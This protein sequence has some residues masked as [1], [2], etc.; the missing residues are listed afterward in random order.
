MTFQPDRPATLKL[1]LSTATRASDGGALTVF[2]AGSITVLTTDPTP[3]ATLTPNFA[4]TYKLPIPAALR[5]YS[6]ATQRKSGNN[7]R[8]NM[9]DRTTASSDYETEIAI[10]NDLG[11]A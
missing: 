9:I 7:L 4:T 1:F 8:I 5:T 3:L 2:P 11:H 10:G 6:G